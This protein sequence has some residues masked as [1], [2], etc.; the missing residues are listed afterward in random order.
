MAGD[1]EHIVLTFLVKHAN[2]E[3][4]I[5]LVSDQA[6]MLWPHDIPASVEVTR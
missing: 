6:A 5:R 3:R 2:R 4:A 1:D